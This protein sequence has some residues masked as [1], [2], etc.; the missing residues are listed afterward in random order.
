M[1]S[2]D[3]DI[4]TLSER[5]KAGGTQEA[6]CKTPDSQT[7]PALSDATGVRDVCGAIAQGSPHSSALAARAHLTKQWGKLSEHMAWLW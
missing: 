6:V 4:V 7:L 5:R 1:G 2:H 3:L